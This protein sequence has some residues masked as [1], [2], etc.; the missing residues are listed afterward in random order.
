[1]FFN[2]FR[3]KSESQK[4]IDSIV[5][6]NWDNL[7]VYVGKYGPEKVSNMIL[8]HYGVDNFLSFVD[9]VDDHFDDGDTIPLMVAQYYVIITN[10]KYFAGMYYAWYFNNYKIH[11]LL[12]PSIEEVIDHFNIRIGQNGVRDVVM[13]QTYY[14][15]DIIFEKNSM[16]ADEYYSLTTS[17]PRCTANP[18]N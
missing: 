11:Q 12:A 3:G 4:I 18:D 7:D 9:I 13:N 6:N 8:N 10:K 14:Y 16:R 5:E 2:L 15:P 17:Y 1:M